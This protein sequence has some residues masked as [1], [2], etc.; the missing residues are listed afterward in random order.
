MFGTNNGVGPNMAVISENGLVG[1]IVSATNTTSKVQTIVDPASSVSSTLSTTRD[2][3]VCKGM[4]E[5]SNRI[6]ATFIPTEAN[7]VIGDS[8]ETSG[9]GGIYPK[10]IHIG[11]IT[12]IKNTK[13][14]IDRYALVE[15]AVDFSKLETV[16]V[17]I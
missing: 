17:V 8:I 14:T 15:T 6:K 12:E 16:L 1:Y 11:N 9:M 10:G 3:I 7:L 13:N 4:L 2:A 5:N